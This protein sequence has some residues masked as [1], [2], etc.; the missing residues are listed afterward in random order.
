MEEKRRTLPDYRG[1]VRDTPVTPVTY[2]QERP[3]QSGER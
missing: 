3:S 1:T 2:R